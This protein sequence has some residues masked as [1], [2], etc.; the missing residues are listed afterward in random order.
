LALAGKEKGKKKRKGG[1]KNIDFS[2]VKC[3][4]CHKM[5]HF[6]SQCPERKKKKPQM[7]TLA[8][9]DEFT[10][11]FE[12]DFCFIA[13][14]SS[15]TVLDMW[16]VNNGASCHMIGRKE[17]FTRLQ[18]GGVNLVIELGDDMHYKAQ[19][20]GTVSFQR[21]SGKPLRFSD[22]L[23]VPGLTKNFIS[24]ST[25][26]DTGYEVNFHKGKVF[27]RSGGSGEKMDRMIGV[28]EEKVYRLQV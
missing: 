1:K 15:T 6:A 5:G 8:T 23:Y 22:V 28:R 21:E 26:E 27:I 3:F 25:L 16:F 24:V 14:M 19:G 11:S 12:E 17:W 10:K 18:E 9:V 7:G 2:K 13:C 20:V 4:Q